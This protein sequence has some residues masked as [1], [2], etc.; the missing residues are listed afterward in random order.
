MFVYIQLESSAEAEEK[1]TPLMRTLLAM[2]SALDSIFWVRADDGRFVYVNA[3]CRSLGFARSEW[4]ELSVSDVNAD[5]SADSW[6]QLATVIR[7]QGTHSLEAIHRRKD[8]ETFPVE[9]VINHLHC[10][11]AE[12]YCAHARNISKRKQAEGLLRQTVEAAK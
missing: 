2:D 7:E 12:L 3:A 9:L 6:P 8:G 5:I 10:D 11:G 4:L 1:F